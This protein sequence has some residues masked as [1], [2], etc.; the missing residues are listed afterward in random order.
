MTRGEGQWAISMPFL[1]MWLNN[2]PGAAFLTCVDGLPVD[3][4]LNQAQ[5]EEA[6]SKG[7][8]VFEILHDLTLRSARSKMDFYTW[9]EDRFCLP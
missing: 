1:M 5:F 9:G 6:I 8:Q 4:N 7:A 3:R 2:V